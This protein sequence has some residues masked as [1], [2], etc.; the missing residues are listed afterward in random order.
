VYLPVR[1]LSVK[2]QYEDFWEIAAFRRDVLRIAENTHAHLR[3]FADE[4]CAHHRKVSG[5]DV[6]RVCFVAGGDSA[7]AR[8]FW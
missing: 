1:H 8:S 6:L 2:L 5:I 4:C 7:E 3:T